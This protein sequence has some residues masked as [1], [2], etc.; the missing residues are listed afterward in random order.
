MVFDRLWKALGVHYR[1]RPGRYTVLL[2]M[3]LTLLLSQPLLAGH[4][5]TQI[6]VSVVMSAM[7][8][9][10]LYTFGSSRTYFVI[11]LILLVPTLVG[12]WVLQ[13]SRIHFFEVVTATGTAAFL[14]L[15][16]IGLIVELFRVK[17]VTLDTISAAICAY[18]LMALAWGFVFALIE[19]EHPGSFSAG[20]IVK[21]EGDGFSPVLTALH[22]FVYYSFVCLTTTGYGDIA[23]LS[24]SARLFS[25]LE[26]MFGQLYLAVLIARLVSIE[27]AQSMMN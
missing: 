4:R 25:V 11:A 23:P 24:L 13:F 21:G 19:L 16:V 15:T 3:I 14:M 1:H 7:L 22:D 18:M 5:D 9:S 6:L 17:R 2:I 10:A 26:A 20:L 27:V 12:R 8:L